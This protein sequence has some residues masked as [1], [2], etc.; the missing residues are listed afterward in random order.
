MP[1]CEC[2]ANLRIANNMEEFSK[3]VYPELSYKL[4]GILFTVH[5]EL[6]RFCNEK[7]YGD[8]VEKYLKNFIL[9]TKE[10]KIYHPLLIKNFQI[11]IE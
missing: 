7:Q 11:G 6:G 3:L 4:L 1:I 10:K 5:N 9:H 8:L 2:N